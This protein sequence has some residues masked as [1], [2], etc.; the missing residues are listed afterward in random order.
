MLTR[1]SNT[2]QAWKHCGQNLVRYNPS[3]T[4]YIRARVAG[5]LHVKSLETPVLS[6]ARQRLG[7]ELRK[8]RA[9][10]ASVTA[11]SKGKMCV[12]DAIAIYRDRLQANNNIKP[13]TRAYY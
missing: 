11:V 4:Y 13:R 8:L 9:H 3:G 5:K 6:V 1:N 10:A 7:D 12:G 2:E